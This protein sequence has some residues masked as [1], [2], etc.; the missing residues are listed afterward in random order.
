MTGSDPGLDPMR[1]AVM[2]DT[3]KHWSVMIH[4]EMRKRV[5]HPACMFLFLLL[6]PAR[7]LGTSTKSLS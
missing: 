6:S 1:R 2:G 4:S 5:T 7:L 3:L